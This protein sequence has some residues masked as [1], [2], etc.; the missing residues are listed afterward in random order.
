MRGSTEVW[1]RGGDGRE[2]TVGLGARMPR[3]APVQEPEGRRW[4][5]GPFPVGVGSQAS[6][7]VKGA[8]ASGAGAQGTAR[9]G[10]PVS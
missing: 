1:G 7:A 4:D 5:L 8:S 10:G 6:F 9:A 3:L 2:E